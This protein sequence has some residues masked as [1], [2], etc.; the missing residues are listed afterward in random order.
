MQNL[1]S[2]ILILVYNARMVINGCGEKDINKAIE[3]PD[4]YPEKWIKILPKKEKENCSTGF[5]KYFSCDL[6]AK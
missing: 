5:P 2:R 6:M 4:C 3:N 1:F